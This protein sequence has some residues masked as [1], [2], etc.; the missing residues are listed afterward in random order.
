[1]TILGIDPG[2]AILG[3]SV[4][5]SCL[6]L[7][8]Y[9]V[10]QTD[11]NLDID[12]RLFI[13]HGSLSSIIKTHKPDCLSIEKLF[14][15]KNT[16]TAI[17]VAKAIGSVILTAKIHGLN[18][19]EYSPVQIKK[20]LT[21]FGNAPKIQMQNMIKTIFKLESIPQPDDAADAVAIAL[22]HALNTGKLKEITPI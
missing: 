20:S 7:H 17:D 18:I 12:N 5:D 4:I 15:Q 3:W 19:Y 21:G 16:K 1:V 2:Y 13:I 10:I 8:D 22:C 11:S 14:F 6:K 9:G